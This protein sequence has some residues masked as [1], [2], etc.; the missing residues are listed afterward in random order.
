MVVS[1]STGNGTHACSL[2]GLAPVVGEEVTVH[3]TGVSLLLSTS[4]CVVLSPPIEHRE[5]KDQR[6]NGQVTSDG[7]ART[8]S[9]SDAFTW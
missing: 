5:T 7:S 2:L 4:V 1:G 8:L 6:F 3:N 9:T